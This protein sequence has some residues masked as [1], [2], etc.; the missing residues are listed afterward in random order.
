M[1]KT[2][3]ISFRFFKYIQTGFLL[4][5]FFKKLSEM[6]IKNIFIYSSLFFGEKYIIEFLTKKI[7]NNLL[8]NFSKFKKNNLNYLNY[9]NDIYF[10]FIYIYI[11]IY[12]IIFIF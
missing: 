8:F 12:I 11:L 5:F 9:F 3:L 1:L 2:Y 10:F 6:I 4:D 7:I